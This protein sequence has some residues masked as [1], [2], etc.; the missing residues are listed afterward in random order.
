[1]MGKLGMS[2]C[3]RLV[4]LQV[5]SFLDLRVMKN[6]LNIRFSEA[7]FRRLLNVGQQDTVDRGGNDRNLLNCPP[8]ALSWP[9]PE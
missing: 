5:T 3:K 1:M 2:H 9:S 7:A 6:T 4:H 8:A